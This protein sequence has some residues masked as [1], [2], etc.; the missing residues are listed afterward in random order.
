MV[1]RIPPR[2]CMGF[3]DISKKTVIGSLDEGSKTR[4]FLESLD[5]D[6]WQVTAY[7]PENRLVCIDVT[8]DLGMVHHMTITLP[9][10]ST[11][12]IK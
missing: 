10:I 1:R 8:S 3:P 2:A 12:W 9:I 11:S 6:Q 5:D 7:E 4:E